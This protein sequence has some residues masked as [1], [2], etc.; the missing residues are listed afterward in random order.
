MSVQW[1]VLHSK[2]HREEALS[3]HIEAK[4]VEYYYPR[5]HVRPVNPRSRR[6]RPYFPGY[7]FVRADL[8]ALGQGFF[9]WMPEAVGLVSFG[10]EPAVIPDQ[11]MQDL[12]QLLGDVI[13]A[14][15][16]WDD[17]VPGDPLLIN[18]GPFAGYQAIF[19]RR[20]AGNKRV[21]VLL[22]MLRGHTISLDLSSAQIKRVR[23]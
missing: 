18:T 22:E 4:A 10:G 17:L 14:G 20:L 15:T 21:R 12:R 8:E 23:P 3:R 2:A 11:L 7:L 13:D 9:Q 1:Y 19:D 16:E 6:V 5:L